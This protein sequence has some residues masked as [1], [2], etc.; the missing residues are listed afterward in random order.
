MGCCSPNKIQESE[1]IHNLSKIKDLKDDEIISTIRNNENNENIN[2]DEDKDKIDNIVNISNKYNFEEKQPEVLKQEKIKDKEESGFSLISSSERDNTTKISESDYQNVL[3]LYPE[4]TTE[5]KDKIEIKKNMILDDKSI[6]YGEY[7]T[8]KNIKEG[9]GILIWPNGA[10]YTGYFQNNMQ[11]IK[12]KIYHA[13]GDIYEGEWLDDKANGEGKY[14]R[15]GLIYE[16]QWKNDRQNGHGIEKLDD[17]SYYE[18]DFVNGKKEGKGKYVWADGSSYIGEFKDNAFNG[19]GKYIWDN[20]REYDGDWVKGKME[21]K[22]IFKWPDGRRF[23]GNY[24]N[25]KKEGYGE[26]F[27][28]DGKIFKG[29]WK[30]GLQNGEGEMYDPK[31]NKTKKGIWEDGKIVRWIK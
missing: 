9:R 10:K 5:N 14:I 19:K 30:N 8:E 24:V 23:E 7:N 17:G 28:S 12:G 13:D 18:G 15:K 1:F 21:G 4:L 11:N 26:Y 31:K 20:R 2:T 6:Y 29:M 16:G 25:D 27:F 22:G 3:S